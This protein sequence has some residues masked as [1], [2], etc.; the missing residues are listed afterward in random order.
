MDCKLV[1]THLDAYVDGELEPT[2]VLEF[3]RHLDDCSQCRNEVDLSQL[4]QQGVQA[5]PLP[6]IPASLARRVNRALDAQQDASEHGGPGLRSWPSLAGFSA[7]ALVL[8]AVGVSINPDHAPA[9]GAAPLGPVAEEAMGL[10][11]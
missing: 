1:R 7:A 11:G 4:I 6:R 10:F 3:E 8:M 9:P 5:L 2:P